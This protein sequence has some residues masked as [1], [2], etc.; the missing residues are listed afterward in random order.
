[1]KSKSSPFG[2]V[3]FNYERFDRSEAIEWL[4]RLNGR[5]FEPLP[6]HGSHPLNNMPNKRRS[7]SDWTLTT[8]S[9]RPFG[10]QL[11]ERAGAFGKLDAGL[12]TFA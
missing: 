2:D 1:M 7:P 6:P 3:P 9:T 10:S 11:A 4:E 12:R 5:R 8:P